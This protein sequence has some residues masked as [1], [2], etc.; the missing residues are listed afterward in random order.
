MSSRWAR[1]EPMNWDVGDVFTQ[2]K[3]P[4]FIDRVMATTQMHPTGTKVEKSKDS[5]E[6]IVRHG[7]E[8]AGTSLNK[9]GTP[10][11]ERSMFNQSLISGCY[12][13]ENITRDIGK[14]V[15]RHA[16]LERNRE[17]ARGELTF[18]NLTNEQARYLEG[19]L[20]DLDREL[21]QLARQKDRLELIRDLRTMKVNMVLSTETSRSQDLNVKKI[22]NFPDQV[23]HA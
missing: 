7:S 21:S 5:R 8:G 22:G 20:G 16:Q 19:S 2:S 23:A 10:K 15:Q 14:L 4:L 3:R 9:A 13:V 1:A 12:V 6:W 11:T 18:K 17:I